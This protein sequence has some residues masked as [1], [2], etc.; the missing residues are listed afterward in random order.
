MPGPQR[1]MGAAMKRSKKKRVASGDRPFAR[2]W[3]LVRKV[4][5]GK[6]ITYGQLSAMIDGRLTPV[7]VGW[8]TDS[9]NRSGA[10]G[11]LGLM[12]RR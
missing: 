12:V 8:A 7:G 2:V 10:Y 3:A 5:R 11:R 9:D 4:P 6:V 1:A